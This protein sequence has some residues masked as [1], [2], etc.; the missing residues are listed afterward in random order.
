VDALELIKGRRSIR[1][2]RPE[3]V[4]RDKVIYCLEA[5]R[6][7]PSAGNRQPWEF[8]VVTE[9]ETRKRLAEVHRWGRHMAEAPVVVVALA[10]PSRDPS[11][12]QQDLGAAI[13]N[14]MLAAYSQGL[15]TCWIGVSGNPEYEE[16]F[17]EILGVPSHLRV[18]TAITLGYPAEAPSKDRRPLDEIV[19][20]ERYGRRQ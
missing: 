14:L 18:V 10:D 19:H 15:G 12:W 6:W 20:W 17:R 9:P 5:A 11:Y 13:Q 4:E 2:Y 16:K 3:P 8:I 7:A 1:R